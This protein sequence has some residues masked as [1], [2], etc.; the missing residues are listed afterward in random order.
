MERRCRKD[1]RVTPEGR[2]RGGAV[3]SERHGKPGTQGRHG[4][5][6][7]DRASGSPPGS[8]LAHAGAA[9][10]ASS[11][12]DGWLTHIDGGFGWDPSIWRQC[13]TRPGRPC[14][15]RAWVDAAAGGE[16]H[17]YLMDLPLVLTGGHGRRALN[18][19][20]ASVK[21]VWRPTRPDHPRPEVHRRWAGGR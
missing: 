21:A 4:W 7:S 2:T 9:M 14:W 18:V 5:E 3:S 20:V 1:V 16:P 11:I 12:F 13:P 6:R 19:A 10:A 17:Q 15:V 8:R